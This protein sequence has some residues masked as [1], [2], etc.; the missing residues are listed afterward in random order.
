MRA[1][2]WAVA[3]VAGLAL[4][5]CA[6]IPSSGPVRAGD[7]RIDDIQGAV[8][9]ADG[10][11]PGAT[12]KGIVEGLLAAGAAGLTGDFAVAREFLTHE[13]AQSWQPL[14]GAIVTSEATLEQTPEGQ[15]TATLQVIGEV[16][17]GGCFIE[18][19]AERTVVFD[20]VRVDGEWRVADLPPGLIVSASTF[21]QQYRRT[22]V[23]FLTP[24]RTRAVPDV[25]YFPTRNLATSVMQALLAG[26]SPWLRDAV[27]SAI[28]EGV[29]LK[30]EVVR[31]DEDGT[32]QVVLEPAQIVQAAPDRGLMLA[33]ITR[34]LEIPQVRSVEVRAGQDGALLA[35]P[36]SLTVGTMADPVVLIG[37]SL[38]RLGGNLAPL[39]GVDPLVG[40]RASAPAG[41]G[42][43]SFQVVLS[44]T[45]RL[46]QV[47]TAG[48]PAR[49][50][51]T[52]RGLARP[53]VDV[54]GWVWT[55][56]S[57]PGDGLRV[58]DVEAEEIRVRAP[59]LDDRTVRAVRVAWD[60]A[61][62]A[63]VSS[64]P[65]GVAVE[66]SAVIRDVQGA[67][68]SLGPPV[69]VGPGLVSAD[70]VVWFD[71]ATLVVLGR[72]AE[73]SVLTEVPVTGV[74]RVLAPVPDAAVLAAGGWDRTLLVATSSG[75]L[76]RR[77]SDIWI[78]V[79]LGEQQV[80]DLAYPG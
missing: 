37:D 16:A 7:V 8:A 33:Q 24:D 34:S 46:V 74:S 76:L 12:P 53:S 78:P 39:E 69:Q 63:V 5:G 62:V 75:E 41:S 43:G 1:R 64:G 42:D 4:G 58:V 55:A 19:G 36:S 21:A 31:I 26:P 32:A 6:T 28:P 18:V 54:H 56:R 47:P 23:Y 45:D 40:L 68:E 17:E 29:R 25:R 51:L 20:L 9:V 72:G 13:A 11:H 77:Y 73:G 27:V 30:P 57:V 3:L 61:R 67:P 59:W 48:M 49:T 79:G 80:R 35:G 44:G 2:V 71:A 22:P 66:V 60:G 10:P 15:V 14:A 50:L 65:T 38:M 70:Q 52:G